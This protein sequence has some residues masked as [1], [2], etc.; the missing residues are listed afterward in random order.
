MTRTDVMYASTGI[1]CVQL[2]PVA[3]LPRQLLYEYMPRSCAEAAA[4]LVVLIDG[5]MNTIQLPA[6][7]S[8]VRAG[9]P[10]RVQCS[11]H[12]LISNLETN[13]SLI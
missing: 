5:E 13:S 1:D 6:C 7:T 12:V 3:T 8:S 2:S 10:C 11:E 9:P 4:G